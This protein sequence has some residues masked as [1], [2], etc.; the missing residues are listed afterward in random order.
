MTMVEGSER[1]WQAL[2][3]AKS[4]RVPDT[5]ADMIWL[6]EAQGKDKPSPHYDRLLSKDRLAETLYAVRDPCPKCGTRQDI[7]CRHTR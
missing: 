5:N 4:G 7:G 3:R 1:L 2:D 6:T